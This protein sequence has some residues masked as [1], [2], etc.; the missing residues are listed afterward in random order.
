[1]PS[2]HVIKSLRE[3]DS[4]SVRQPIS[5]EVFGILMS[6]RCFMQL[7]INC[8]VIYFLDLGTKSAYGLIF[9]RGLKKDIT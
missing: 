5:Y 9:K 1:M 6:T 3:D 4:Y 8:E 7:W 2:M